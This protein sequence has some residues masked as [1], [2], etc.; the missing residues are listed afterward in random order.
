MK[1]LRARIFSLKRRNIKKPP[2]L[3]PAAEV[4]LSFA[5]CQKVSRKPNSI[6]RC[7]PSEY[8]PV[9][10]PTRYASSSDRVVPLIDPVPAPFKTPNIVV[11]GRWDT[12]C[13]TIRW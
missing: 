13:G 7:E 3:M 11:G 1:L 4:F 8:T 5:E 6:W 2:V 9:P 12:P 10:L